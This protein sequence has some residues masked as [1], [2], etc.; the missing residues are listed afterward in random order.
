MGDRD[1]GGLGPAGSRDYA[2][3]NAGTWYNQGS[4]YGSYYTYNPGN[5][6]DSY[7]YCWL[8]YDTEEGNSSHLSGTVQPE[9]NNSTGENR[10]QMPE[11]DD[12]APSF[13]RTMVEAIFSIERYKE[14]NVGDINQDGIPDV[15]AANTT[16]AAGRLYQAVEDPIELEEGGDLRALARPTWMRTSCPR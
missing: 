4:M 9:V 11:A 13:P 15:Y 12:E 5:G 16:W 14:D 8:F 10:V 2:V 6:M 1:N 3:D 7:F